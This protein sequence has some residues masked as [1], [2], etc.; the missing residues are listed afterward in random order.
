MRNKLRV[1][2]TQKSNLDL[3]KSEDDSE[4]VMDVE[5]KNWW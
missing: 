5:C 1:A 3:N 2:A 4:M